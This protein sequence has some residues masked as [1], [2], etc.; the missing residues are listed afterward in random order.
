MEVGGQNTT[1]A[2]EYVGMRSN[3]YRFGFEGIKE[4]F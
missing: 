1:N 3:E 2:V 4:Y